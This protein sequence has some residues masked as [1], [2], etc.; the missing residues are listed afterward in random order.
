MQ[1][2]IK[3]GILGTLMHV[4]ERDKLEILEDA[5]VIEKKTDVFFRYLARVIQAMIITKIV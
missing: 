2:E 1:S 3:F 4:P 5:L